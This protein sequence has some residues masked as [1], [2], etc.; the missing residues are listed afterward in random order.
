[1]RPYESLTY[2]GQAGRV[3]EIAKRVVD[4][5]D[6]PCDKLELI[7]H[8][9]NTTFRVRNTRAS[10]YLVRVHRPGYQNRQT[11]RSELEFLSAL[12]R[13][14]ELIVPR[15]VGEGDGDVVRF[16]APGVELRDVVAFEWIPG[17]FSS[18][19]SPFKMERL[20]RFVAQLHLYAEQYTPSERFERQFW[21]IDGLLGE[22][23]GGGTSL[24]PEAHRGLTEE[25]VYRADEVF[26]R[27]GRD[28]DVWG[29]IHA[30]LHHGNRLIQ[31]GEVAAIDFDDLGFGHYLYDL[32]VILGW[33]YRKHREAYPELLAAF[34]RGYRERRPIRDDHVA[35]LPAFFAMR[36]LAITL[37]VIGRAE[38]NPH[39][40]ARAKQ[41]E[42]TFVDDLRAFADLDW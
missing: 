21:N 37:W 12:R 17:R 33:P 15:P 23:M 34:L 24:L 14:T 30:D 7:F 3:R 20:G 2:R 27:L 41:Y 4:H 16:D 22:N 26:N 40:A 11:I 29:V 19:F 8:G 38:D 1:M 42:K 32:A 13:D 28:P 36:F 25:V 39:F 31:N 9:E 35:V 10:D 6:L 18:K 5:F